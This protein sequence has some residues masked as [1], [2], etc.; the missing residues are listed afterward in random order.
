ME[1][2]TNTLTPPPAA[3]TDQPGERPPHIPEKFWDP[4]TGRIRVDALL[5]SYLELERKLAGMV[6][7]PGPDAAPADKDR[8]LSALGRPP[9]PEAY[10]IDCNHGLFGPDEEVNRRLHAAGMTNDQAQTV[11][12]LAAERM[13][14][15]VR[16]VAA[17]FGAEGELRRL[18]DHFGGE[19]KW[20]EVSRQMLAW[21]RR[22]LPADAI[23]GLASSADGVLA[24]YRMMTGKEP[25]ALTGAGDGEA[26]E[27]RELF[28]M[29]RDPRYWRD[30]DPAFVERVSE[31]FRRLYGEGDGA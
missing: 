5:K 3:V 8:L 27:E 16:E 15:M 6:P 18:V 30:K 12:D 4:K 11:Y 31:G 22:N 23:E 2:E 21:A 1:T 7:A 26:G 28:A 10:C 14:P 13:V 24:L 29:M 17:R 25:A 20:R 9:S 19:D